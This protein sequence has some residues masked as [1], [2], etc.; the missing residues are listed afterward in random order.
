MYVG[1]GH[2]VYLHKIHSKKWK[3]ENIKKM[4]ILANDGISDL[5][6]KLLEKSLL[7]YIISLLVTKNLSL[8]LYFIL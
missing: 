8:L 3:N 5:G 4:K 1:I 7:D 6:K 2:A